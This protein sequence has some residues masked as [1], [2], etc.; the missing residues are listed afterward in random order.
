MRQ[1]FFLLAW[2]LL[3]L[4]VRALGEIVADKTIHWA[5][6]EVSANGTLKKLLD[7]KIKKGHIPES[8][9]L[10]KNFYP[11]K[12]V[13]HRPPSEEQ[14][15]EISARSKPLLD[16]FLTENNLNII[17][18]SPNK[19]KFKD[20]VVTLVNSG[21]TDNRIDL[22]LMGD[23]YTY[24]EKDK[25]Y[26]DMQRIVDDLFKE[27]TFQSYLPLLNVHLVFRPS[28]ESGIGKNG[29]PKDTAYQL[30]RPGDTLRAIFAGN[31]D[32]ARD[33]CD[34]APDCDY[35]ILI[36]ND[37]NYG[38]LGGEFAIST[39]SPSSGS[40]VLRH[41]LGHTI[42]RVGEE[43]DGGG[44]FGA[45]FS[46]SI[47][48]LK[49][50]HFATDKD[51]VTPEP[52]RMLHVNWPWV[53]LKNGPHT[54]IFDSMEP[55]TKGTIQFSASGL[56]KENSLFVSLDNKLQKFSNPDKADRTFVHMDYNEGFGK[57]YHS[58]T[59]SENI[60]DENN[61]LSSIS[62]ME[63]KDEYHFDNSFY[64]AYPVYS[65]SNEVKGFRPTHNACL[66]RNM[67]SKDFC[68]VCQENNW[69]QFFKSVTLIDSLTSSISGN[70]TNIHLN[71]LKLGQ[72]NLEKPKNSDKLLIR[73][74]K[75]AKEEVELKDKILISGNECQMYGDWTAITEFQSDEIKSPDKA[76]LK[77]LASIKI[78]KNPNCK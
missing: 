66:M 55:F 64:G 38:G 22:V 5:K 19:N 28:N 20:E 23:G 34:Q 61:W 41:E 56:E 8:M 13:E 27:D 69:R 17:P 57:G 10:E 9:D 70:N 68:K 77:D 74:F 60:K 14:I 50:N 75:N 39:S 63:Y 37:P 31:A 26:M 36:G 30:Y 11:Q 29:I 32:A 3:F 59:F 48:D 52:S 35:P 53:N 44:Y 33:S 49:W 40:M 71:G 4:N 15:L 62:I 65:K 76:W 6:I 78:P 42:G 12:I 18:F 54:I 16:R 1:N 51:E 21:P 43:Y 67:N 46:P 45:N 25:F 47:S 72:L 7:R 58:L 73:W 24:S 2:I